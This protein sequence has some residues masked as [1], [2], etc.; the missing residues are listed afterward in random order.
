MTR[1][2]LQ[3]EPLIVRRFRAAL[4]LARRA[5]PAPLARSVAADAA[6]RLEQ[7]D[8]RGSA[9]GLCCEC[10]HLRPVGRGWRC[11]SERGIVARPQVEHTFLLPHTCEGRLVRAPPD[12]APGASP[13]RRAGRPAKLR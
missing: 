10:A 13:L 12:G 2:R 6:L 1:H 3:P 5:L 9:C 8:R 7:R 11:T 4:V